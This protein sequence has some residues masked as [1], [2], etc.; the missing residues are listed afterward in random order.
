M[1]SACL[2]VVYTSLALDVK[3]GGR[4]IETPKRD[5]CYTFRTTPT[6]WHATNGKL[7]ITSTTTNPGAVY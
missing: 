7:Q 3:Q 2:F 5:A 1:R 6:L 4:N